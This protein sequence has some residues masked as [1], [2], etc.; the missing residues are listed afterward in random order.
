MSRTA[1]AIPI[2]FPTPSPT[3]RRWS[4][5]SGCDGRQSP[6][7][8][9]VPRPAGRARLLKSAAKAARRQAK[10]IDAPPPLADKKTHRA[11]VRAVMTLDANRQVAV[12]EDA[13]GP[14]YTVT[15]A[16]MAAHVSP[17]P[18]QR[19]AYINQMT[20][21]ILDPGNLIAITD[22]TVPTLNLP[23]SSGGGGGSYKVQKV[24][25]GGGD[26]TPAQLGIA[27]APPAPC[28]PLSIYCDCA[29]GL[30]CSPYR[31]GNGRFFYSWDKH[32]P[33]ERESRERQR[34]R[35]LHR[36]MWNQ[37]QG[38]ACESMA[39]GVPLAVLNS[40]AT[41]ASCIGAVGTGG[42][43]AVACAASAGAAAVSIGYTHRQY[44]ACSARYPG[45]PAYCN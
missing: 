20:S 3:P 14:R 30:S 18:A 29:F 2:R 24:P 34:C 9:P 32:S 15:F 6:G 19:A 21:S 27:F 38:A 39:A 31:D 42:V 5:P 8:R 35:A 17:D 28:G 26:E 16:E 37:Q 1:P 43:L 33:S 13:A 10:R 22:A 36:D 41:I 4:P 11:S 40:I 23:N 44:Q 45:P 25:D 12:L 7:A